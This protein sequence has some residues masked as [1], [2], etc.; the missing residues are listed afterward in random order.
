MIFTLVCVKKK[1]KKMEKIKVRPISV[2]NCS[3]VF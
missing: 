2:Y 1:K 3:G